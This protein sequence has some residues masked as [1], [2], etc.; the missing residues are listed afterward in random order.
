MVLLG[1]D[2][3]D[4]FDQEILDFLTNYIQEFEEVGKTQSES[5]IK[6]E[7]SEISL[8]DISKR[9]MIQKVMLKRC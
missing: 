6:G 5:D 1:L 3:A 9:G 4:D 7:E 2:L 8:T